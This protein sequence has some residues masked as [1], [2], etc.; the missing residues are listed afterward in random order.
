[1]LTYSAAIADVWHSICQL[2]FVVTAPFFGPFGFITFYEL[3]YNT[4]LKLLPAFSN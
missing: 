1:M 3:Q 4:Q 2:S